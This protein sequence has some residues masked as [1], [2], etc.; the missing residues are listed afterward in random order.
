MTQG[1]DR[2]EVP[3]WERPGAVRRDCEPHRGD[4]LSW[5]GKASRVLSLFSCRCFFPCLLGFPL[6]LTTW[7][8]ARQDLQQMQTG[9]RD[10]GG[11]RETVWALRVC[12]LSALAWGVVVLLFSR[13]NQPPR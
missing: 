2:D 8:L 9:R 12:L 1:V 4:V 5:L 6:G 3:P 11:Q 13:L 7:L 10:R